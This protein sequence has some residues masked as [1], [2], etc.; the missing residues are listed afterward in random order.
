MLTLLRLSEE[1]SSDKKIVP[2]AVTHQDIASMTGTVREVVSRTMLKLKKGEIIV[3][4]SVRGFKV[5]SK[6]LR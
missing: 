4:S 6:L 5:V 1:K 2:L 3:D